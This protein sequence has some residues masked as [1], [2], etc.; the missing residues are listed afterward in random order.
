MELLLVMVI[1]ATVLGGGVG[2]FAALDMTQRTTMSELKSVLRRARMSAVAESS[3]TRVRI[4]VKNSQA[5][6]EVL[7]TVGTWHFEGNMTGARG[8]DGSMRGGNY[9]DDGY[10]GRGLAFRGHP[11]SMAEI[12]VH[13]V[14]ACDLHDGFRFTFTLLNDG[15]GRVLE[16]GRVFQVDVN[17]E[18]S[19]RASFMAELQNNEVGAQPGGQVVAQSAPG[20]VRP[21]HWARIEVVYDRVSLRILIDG[22]EVAVTEETAPV[23][24][25]DSPLT[26]GSERRAYSGV[27][28][29]LVLSVVV[30]EEPVTLP[31]DAQ[32][33]ADT[34]KQI[35]F[36]SGGSLDRRVHEEPVI[37]HV[38]FDNGE[39]ETVSVG[40]FGTVEG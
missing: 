40:T 32:F 24:K 30:A 29:S 11:G 7:Q 33:P 27:V 20:L 2:L 39:R 18:G 10:L 3:S 19:V 22:L 6:A 15:G 28:D 14:S 9:S 34:P 21:E 5:W 38:D 31:L 36:Q 12:P 17:S 35:L 16:I 25:I 4:D 1:L 13:R 23:W 8:I 26:I 37:L